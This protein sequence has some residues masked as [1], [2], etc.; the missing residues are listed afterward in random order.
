MPL[1]SRDLPFD[2][3]W[4]FF[5]GP[6]PNDTELNGTTCMSGMMCDPSYVV[7]TAAGWII[8]LEIPHDWSIQDLPDRA[9]DTSTPVLEIR[10][11]KSV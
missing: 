6:D 7:S 9:D 1:A 8:G 4:S 2:N 3:D 11:G 5:R 10:N